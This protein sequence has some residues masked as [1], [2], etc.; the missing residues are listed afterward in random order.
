[1]LSILV[2]KL[3]RGSW[4][5]FSFEQVSIPTWYTWFSMGIESKERITVINWSCN[6]HQIRIFLCSHHPSESE[7]ANHY[8]SK[9]REHIFCKSVLL[10][11]VIL[12]SSVYNIVSFNTCGQA[13]PSSKLTIIKRRKKKVINIYTYV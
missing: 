9:D 4:C 13:G 8:D 11:Y 7:D 5:R 1:M 6:K 2:K 12:F 10:W 3:E